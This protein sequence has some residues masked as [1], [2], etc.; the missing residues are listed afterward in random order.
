M[1]LLSTEH[2]PG[3]VIDVEE[4]TQTETNDDSG[5][6]NKV[7]RNIPK[8]RYS[9]LRDSRSINQA[10]DLIQGQQPC[11]HGTTRWRTAVILWL[12]KLMLS[13]ARIIYNQ[14][15]PNDNRDMKEMM[16]RVANQLAPHTPVE[17]KLI[18]DENAKQTKK[19]IR[20]TLTTLE[21]FQSVVVVFS[22]KFSADLL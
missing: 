15:N 9:Y 18:L 13:N 16:L 19:E 12:F 1:A 10:N 8:A 2:Q 3:D 20:A 6:V 21:V 7:S 14:L 11:T 5:H 4:E 22:A 17:H